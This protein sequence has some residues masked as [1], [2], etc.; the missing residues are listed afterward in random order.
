[1]PLRM[2]LVHVHKGEL[3]AATAALERSLGIVQGLDISGWF[4][5]VASPLGLSYALAGR[6][7]RALPLLE[8]AMQVA[9]AGGRVCHQSLSLAHLGQGYVLAR[10]IDD[11]ITVAQRALDL[12]LKHKERATKRGRCASLARPP[13]IV[14]RLT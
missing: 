13:R 12:A 2:G 7:D 14:I 10:R 3:A 5:M 1:R 4:N 11:A 8:D 6:L 9:V